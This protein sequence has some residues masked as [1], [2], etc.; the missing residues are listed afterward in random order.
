MASAAFQERAAQPR[1]SALRMYSKA[2]Q[3]TV[4][5]KIQLLSP[6]PNGIVSINQ[7]RFCFLPED[8]WLHGTGA[9]RAGGDAEVNG[10]PVQANSRRRLPR[11]PGAR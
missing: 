4:N 3:H 6:K 9:I 8:F 2:I 1:M 11:L 10:I 5:S 7:F